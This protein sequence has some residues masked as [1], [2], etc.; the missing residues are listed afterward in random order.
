MQEKESNTDQDENEPSDYIKG[1]TETLEKVL[2]STNGY[3][4][5]P[6]KKTRK[7]IILLYQLIVLFG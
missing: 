3:Q 7:Y 1:F 2:P 4:Y 6:K 5:D